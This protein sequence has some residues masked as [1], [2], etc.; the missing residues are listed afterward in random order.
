VNN[1]KSYCD[2]LIERKEV[3]PNSSL[4]KAI[5]YLNNHWEAFT[6]FLRVPGVPLTNNENEKLII[7][8]VP[9]FFR[10]DFYNVLKV[11]ILHFL[12]KL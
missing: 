12:A 2:S 3:E 11:K 6:L 5:A 10:P 7:T 9:P 4:G 1:I 8:E